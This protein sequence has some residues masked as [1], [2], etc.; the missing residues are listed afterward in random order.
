MNSSARVFH[1]QFDNKKKKKKEKN[2]KNP[3][4]SVTERRKK[5]R[6]IW[7]E[8]YWPWGAAGSKDCTQ[9]GRP[10]ARWSCYCRMPGSHPRNPPRPSDDEMNWG[11]SSG[12]RSTWVSTVAR[13]STRT[14]RPPWRPS[15][16]DPR[17][18]A[19]EVLSCSLWHP[20][21]TPSLHPLVA[22]HHAPLYSLSTP[23]CFFHTPPTGTVVG[24]PCAI[25]LIKRERFC[26]LVISTRG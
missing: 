1:L 10:C 22:F 24:C 4:M 11:C 13:R 16:R 3:C 14:K 21:R 19:P 20:T 9:R 25:T 18:R 2:P 23:F 6:K 12:S 7:R 5:E 26:D 8:K 15:P 17:P